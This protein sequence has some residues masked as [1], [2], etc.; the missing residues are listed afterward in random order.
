MRLLVLCA[1]LALAGCA[2]VTPPEVLKSDVARLAA[3]ATGV[4]GDARA[5]LQD[6]LARQPLDADTAVRIA[7]LNNPGLEASLATLA[8]ADADRVAA[9]QLPNPHFA[10]SRLRE[11]QL[12]EIERMLSFNVLQLVTLPWRAQYANESLQLARLRA[13]QD[14][15]RTAADTRKAWV[16]A[17]AA[18]QTVNY[19]RDAHEAAEAGAELARRMARVGN[20][21]KLQQAREQA[22][23]ADVAAQQARAEQA[24]VA[25]REKLTRLL[26]LWGADASY[27]LPDRLPDLP[28]ALPERSDIEATALRERLDVRAARDESAYVAGTLGFTRAT[29]FVDALTVGAVHDTIFDNASGARENKNGFEIEVPVPLFDWGQ[30]R[31]ARARASYAQSVARVRDVAVRARS[32]AREA[33]HGWR[34][35]HDLARH[36][37]DGVVPLRR[38]I[39]DEMQLRY[40]G[41]LASVWDLLAETRNHIAAVNAAIE[42][43]RDFWIADTDLQTALTGTSPGAIASPAAAGAGAESAPQGH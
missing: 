22:L 16:Q 28:Q 2:S 15:I 26:G 11:G 42:A 20:F 33:W 13:A 25:A 7:L 31:T 9:A 12:L 35:A 4:T 8:I 19:L 24:A 40:N 37:S 6:L 39:A 29:G 1:A 3:P 21:S 18:R 23:L 30:A 14:V 27:T 34:T 10:F 36:Y 38:F 41:M 43:Q 17:V 5:T 32:E